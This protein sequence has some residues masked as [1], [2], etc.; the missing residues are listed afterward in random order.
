[1][2]KVDSQ[3]ALGV[4]GK[5]EELTLRIHEALAFDKFEQLPL[6][7]KQRQDLIGDLRDFD[8]S[9]RASGASRLWKNDKEF[10]NKLE[11][12]LRSGD[13]L[14]ETC[15]SRL[16]LLAH[17]KRQRSVIRTT[18]RGY[19]PYALSPISTRKVES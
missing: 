8:A 19:K 10:R 12:L 15:T 11:K 17:A 5:L 3:A 1:M 6:L 13:A 9:A 4:L 16:E 14:I 2:M 18:L 7:L